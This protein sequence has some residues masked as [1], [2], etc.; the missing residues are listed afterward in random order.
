M[1]FIIGLSRAKSFWKLGSAVIA[2][3]EKRPYSHAYIRV[4]D[5][6]T[7]LDLVYQATGHGVNVITYSA[8]KTVNIPVREY[9]IEVPEAVGVRALQYM[10]QCLGISYGFIQIAWITISKI[11]RTS[12]A[13][14][15]GTNKMI[16]S[17]FTARVGILLGID[18]TAKLDIFTPSDQDF[19][20]E[21]KQVK[22]LL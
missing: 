5:G 11:F 10:Q 6:I 22:R 14:Q 21:S 9:E 1:K 18:T 7:G 19:L 13:N 4:R 15:N 17:E 12:V 20:L 3:V 8:F 2:E 16:C